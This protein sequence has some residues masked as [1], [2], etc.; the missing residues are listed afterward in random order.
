[1]ECSNLVA[2]CFSFGTANFAE[3][4]EDAE[5]AIDYLLCCVKG[6]R[7]WSEVENQIRAYLASK[8][9]DK[10]TDHY[11]KW[12]DQQVASAQKLMA[13]WLKND[14]EEGGNVVSFD[15]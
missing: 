8:R 4:K 13:P 15:G 10:A 12:V 3:H 6:G 5:R 2:G 1:M 14:F 9:S 7:Q 11:D